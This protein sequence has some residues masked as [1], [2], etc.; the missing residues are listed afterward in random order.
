MAPPKPCCR[1]VD[2]SH[3]PKTG[4]SPPVPGIENDGCNC[5]R[6]SPLLIDVNGN[7]FNLTNAARGV[8]FDIDGN[9]VLNHLSWSDA[10]SD[11][12]WLVLDRNGNGFIDNG[13]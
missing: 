1:Q 5:F 12:A 7:G 4:D 9:G 6:P 2:I 8:D 3:Y 10:N 13:S 11:D